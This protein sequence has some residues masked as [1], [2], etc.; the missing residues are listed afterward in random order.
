[1][2]VFSG[3]QPTGNLHLGNYLGAMTNWVK[4]QDQGECIFSVV[5]MHAIT[6]WQ[7]PKEL[8]TSTRELIAAF[9][10]SGIDPDKSVLFNQ[11]SNPAHAELA[12]IMSCIARIGWL[13]KMTQFK[14]KAGKNR[15]KVSVG[16]Y[17]YPC[18]MS[19]DILAYKATH[20]PVGEDQKQHL[21]L[22]RDSAQKFNHDFEVDFFPQPEPII[23]GPA[24]RVMSLRDGSKKMSKSDASE[25]SRINLSDSN[26]EIAAKIR[27]AKTDP[28]PLPSTMEELSERFE[29]K[30]LINIYAAIADISPQEVLDQFEGQGF[31]QFKPQMADLLVAHFEPIRTEMEKLLEHSDHID[32]ILS[33]GSQRAKA[34]T[35]PI[36][37]EVY[38]IV[39]F[40]RG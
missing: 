9:V 32:Q 16:L 15:E 5:D 1:M 8:L 3:I 18:L 21:E 17:S 38:D 2:R 28:L 11:S 23:Q 12:W 7:D 10:A 14:D 19:A 33:H 35:E 39:G 27:K 24:T 30:N 37:K 31:G 4:M 6:V 22:A 36:M 25:A 40:Y 34:I 13:N 26:E 20:V 29:A